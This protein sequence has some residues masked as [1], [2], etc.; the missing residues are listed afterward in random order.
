MTCFKMYSAGARSPLAMSSAAWSSAASKSFF[1]GWA[2]ANHTAAAMPPTPAMS[3]GTCQKSRNTPMR[4]RGGAD[5]DATDVATGV[6]TDVATDDAGAAV[7]D[8]ERVFSC[9]DTIANL[10]ILPSANARACG[11]RVRANDRGSS[12]LD[13]PLVVRQRHGSQPVSAELRQTWRA[14]NPDRGHSVHRQVC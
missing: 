7:T 4:D 13:D 1:G 11:H 9:S 5:E 14:E 12:I 6:A 8:T 3:S 10:R 2:R